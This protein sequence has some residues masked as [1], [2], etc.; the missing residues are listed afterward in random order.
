MVT[1]PLCGI[2]ALEMAEQA[3]DVIDKCN[4][5]LKELAKRYKTA[6]ETAQGKNDRLSL[7]GATDAESVRESCVFS[8]Y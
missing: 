5:R 8:N 7:L 4:L 1:D 3:Q 2:C 6:S